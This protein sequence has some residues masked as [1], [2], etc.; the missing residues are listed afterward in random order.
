MILDCPPDNWKRPAI[1][2]GVKLKVLMRQL[3][4]TINF[5]HRPALWERKFD[6]V[7]N[8]TIP[9]ANDPNFIEA[10]TVLDHDKRTHGPGGEKRITTA[11]SDSNRR[12]KV[13]RIGPAWSAF[14]SRISAKATGDKPVETPKR[15]QKIPSRPFRRGRKFNTRRGNT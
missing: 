7:A 3:A 4:V 14:M 10:M 1:P 12:A 5:D 6:T 13:N 2:I 9:P 15:K 11:G 8:D